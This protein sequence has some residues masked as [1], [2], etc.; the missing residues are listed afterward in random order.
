LPSIYVASSNAGK[1]A[2]FRL[3]VSLWMGHW[4]KQ[5]IER[6]AQAAPWTLESLP[7]FGRLPACAEDALTFAGNAEKKALH[8]SRLAGG[9]ALAPVLADDSGLEVDALG[10]AP[11]IHSRRFAGPAATDAENNAKLLRQMRGIPRPKRTARFVCEL[12][13]ARD[14]RLL[15]QFRGVAEG[16]LLEAPRGAGG[17]GYDPLFLDVE[18]DRTFAEFSP[19]EKL[20]RSHRGRALRAMLDW[21]LT[22]ASPF[23]G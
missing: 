4:N 9:T 20:R 2:E 21:L 22:H 18:S 19:Q 13:V 14:G 7:D 16:L 11:G 3:G 10:G 5:G 6:A 1:I 23:P 8:Y 12:A 15:A 17:F